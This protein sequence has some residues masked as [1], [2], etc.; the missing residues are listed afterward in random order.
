MP[1]TSQKV[2]T[3]TK[4]QVSSGSAQA[5]KKGAKGGKGK[6]V[7][8]A[9]S[10]PANMIKKKHQLAKRDN[11]LFEANKRNFGI[12]NHIQPKR[13]LTRFV[14]W[15][16]YIR[17][18]RQKR[19]LFQRLKIPGTINQFNLTADKNTT[20][21]LFKLLSLHRPE[22]KVQ[23][24]ERLLQEAKDIVVEQKKTAEDKNEKPNKQAR[25]QQKKPKF[26]KY[27]LKHVTA[28]V[29][30]RKA[31]LVIIANDVDPLELVLWLP[32]LCKKKDIPYIIVKGKAALGRIVHKKT[33]AV[34]CITDVQKANE[35]DLDILVAKARDNYLDRYTEIVKRSGGQVMGAKH[36]AAKAKVEKAKAKE[37]RAVKNI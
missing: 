3:A 7:G 15:P 32:T 24:K 31:R 14:K 13:D 9:K 36:N 12:G 1:K 34:L 10:A 22:T 23:K 29:E 11:P 19:I 26:V 20:N 21:S 25:K 18:Q 27:G 4:P 35:K 17:V 28:L 8:K 33:A 2:A 6:T 37:T 5:S 30:S 16:K